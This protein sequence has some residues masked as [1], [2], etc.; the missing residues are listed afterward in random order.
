MKQT[1]DDLYGTL[2]VG[3]RFLAYDDEL[4]II[5]RLESARGFLIHGR[6]FSTNAYQRIFAF[7]L[8]EFY[9][10]ITGRTKFAGLEVFNSYRIELRTPPDIYADDSDK[11][12]VLPK[13][14]DFHKKRVME[15]LKTDRVKARPVTIPL[16]DPILRPSNPVIEKVVTPSPDQ[17]EQTPIPVPDAQ[18]QAILNKPTLLKIHDYL[19]Y[20]FNPKPVKHEKIISIGVIPE[21]KPAGAFLSGT[22]IDDQPKNQTQFVTLNQTYTTKNGLP[23]KLTYTDGN[24]P[25]PVGGYIEAVVEG[26]NVSIPCYWTNTG[27]YSRLLKKHSLDLI[28][29]EQQ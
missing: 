20:A 9:Q 27:K 24:L 25:Y 23:V 5:T 29:K 18:L 16:I 10:N 3:D 11:S 19:W 7:I 6:A 1:I 8:T 14:S 2:S 12:Y 26:I 4:L 17:Y 15:P 13:S 28:V 22:W 21:L